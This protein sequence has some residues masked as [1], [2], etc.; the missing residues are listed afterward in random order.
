MECGSRLWQSRVLRTLIRRIAFGGVPHSKG[1][2]PAPA[3]SKQSWIKCERP[4]IP[5]IQPS[6]AKLH[7]RLDA[8]DLFRSFQF[9]RSAG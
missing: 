9:Y 4:G 3:T 1:F 6:V 8:H 5:A 7:S 2:F